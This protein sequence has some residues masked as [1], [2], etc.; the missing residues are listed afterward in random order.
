MGEKGQIREVAAGYA[1]NY[2]IPKGLAQRV[3]PGHIKDLKMQDEARSRKTAK[4]IKAA[5]NVAAKLAG[6]EISIKVKAGEAG[7]LFGS[8][9]SA[10]IAEELAMQGIKVDKKKIEL[11]EYIKSLGEYTVQIKLHPEVAASVH[12]VVEEEENL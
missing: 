5:E 10:D 12:V 9:T 7:R 4:A 8:V 11:D 1:R 6:K 3:T 2:L